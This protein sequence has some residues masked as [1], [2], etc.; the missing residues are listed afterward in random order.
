MGG[1]QV[2]L[3][4]NSFHSSLTSGFRTLWEEDGL[5][6]VTLASDGRC[7]QAHKLILS[8]CSPFFREVFK[9]NPCQHPVIILQD[10]HFSE[11]ESLLCFVYKGEVNIDE[12]NLPALL[13]AAETLQIRGL[14]GASEQVTNELGSVTEEI[15]EVAVEENSAPAKRLRDEKW[16]SPSSSNLWKPRSARTKKRTGSRG[17][18]RGAPI[19]VEA[20][21]ETA[22]SPERVPKLEPMDHD[23]DTD[24]D[25]SAIL[26]DAAEDLAD[27]NTDLFLGPVMEMSITPDN[28]VSAS[29]TGQNNDEPIYHVEQNLQSLESNQVFNCLTASKKENPFPPFPCPFCEK[30][31]T[32]W[33]F[34]RRHIKAMHTHSERI[35]CKWCLLVVESHADW[36]NHV[37][38]IH[39]LSPADA[40]NGILILEEANMVL[41]VLNPP[42][43]DTLMTM[44]KGSSSGSQGP[45]IPKQN[46]AEIDHQNT[47][48]VNKDSSKEMEKSIL[49]EQSKQQSQH[50]SR[51]SD[52]DDAVIGIKVERP[53][54]SDED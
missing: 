14:A 8:A 54:C 2:C 40:Q 39:G 17:S 38:L 35:T 5:V 22:L 9:A 23:E 18:A 4:W 41:R 24:G 33:G 26:S 10:T 12:E 43:L 28:S 49:E 16:Q 21:L 47:D 37:T 7:I 29:D 19:S 44:I 34:R 1:G 25:T 42:R 32:S 50:A 46:S 15:E 48:G 11:L 53:G 30:A 51:D 31:Y 3:K 45:S 36:K 27:S 20:V 6:D 52:E 13:R